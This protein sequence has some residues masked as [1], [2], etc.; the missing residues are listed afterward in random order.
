MSLNNVRARLKVLDI[1]AAKMKIEPPSDF[2]E[3]VATTYEEQLD[4]MRN[5]LNYAD[6]EEIPRP[7]EHIVDD[8]TVGRIIS[9]MRLRDPEYGLY[10][11]TIAEGHV[12]RKYAPKGGYFMADPSNALDAVPWEEIVKYR[13]MTRGGGE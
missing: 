13:R 1:S 5:Y 8:W 10:M 3:L 6:S 12:V 4:R 7:L 9:T 11:Q 2:D